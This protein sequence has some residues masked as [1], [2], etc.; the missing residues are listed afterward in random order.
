MILSTVL[1][2]FA[3]YSPIPPPPG[4]RLRARQQAEQPCAQMH[5]HVLNHRAAGVALVLE[6]CNNPK[7]PASASEGPEEVRVFMGRR[8]DDGAGGV[9]EHHCNGS[10]KCASTRVHVR[11]VQQKGMYMFG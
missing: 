6:S 5:G 7:V 2:N 10:N 11:N 9:G 1:R 8:G 3:C 4:Q